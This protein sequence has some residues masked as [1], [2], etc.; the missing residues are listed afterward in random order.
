MTTKQKQ[1]ARGRIV[2]YKPADGQKKE[3][4]IQLDTLVAAG[5][6]NSTVRRGAR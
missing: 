4:Q 3:F 6:T 1:T 5:R 2:G